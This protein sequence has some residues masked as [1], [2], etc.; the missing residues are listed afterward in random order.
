MGNCT[1]QKDNQYSIVESNIKLLSMV[2]LKNT[3]CNNNKQMNPIYFSL[4]KSQVDLCFYD[5]YF[6]SC[7][8]W[9]NNILPDSCLYLN[10]QLK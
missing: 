2:I 5:L 10:F 1:T 8:K 4:E 3:E 7:Q 9:N 6:L